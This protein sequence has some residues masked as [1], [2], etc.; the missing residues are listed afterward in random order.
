LYLINNV[1][2]YDYDSSK[3]FRVPRGSQEILDNVEFNKETLII[4]RGKG[5]GTV[6]ISLD[7]YNS[8]METVHLEQLEFI[9]IKMKI[10]KCLFLI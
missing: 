8:L 6:I 1:N 3:L 4:K 9:E 5:P 10:I 7:E 2:T